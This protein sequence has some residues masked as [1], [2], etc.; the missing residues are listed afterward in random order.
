MT[1]VNNGNN[2]FNLIFSTIILLFYILIYVVP[3]LLLK[4]Y[5]IN[6]K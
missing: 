2:V 1:P 6:K 5:I 4:K 3:C